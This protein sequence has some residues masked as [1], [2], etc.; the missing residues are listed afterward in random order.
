[1]TIRPLVIPSIIREFDAQ[2]YPSLAPEGRKII[3]LQEELAHLPKEVRLIVASYT[4]NATFEDWTTLVSVQ[5]SAARMPET[6]IELLFQE[7]L[8]HMLKE[9]LTLLEKTQAEKLRLIHQGRTEDPEAWRKISDLQLRKTHLENAIKSTTKSETNPSPSSAKK[10]LLLY[11]F[12]STYARASRTVR[13][14]LVY[15]TITDMEFSTWGA[16]QSFAK[17]IMVKTAIAA[18]V[19]LGILAAVALLY[20][21]TCIVPKVY[22]IAKAALGTLLTSMFGPTV[23][24]SILHACPVV[25]IE[26]ASLLSG[27]IEWIV[28]HQMRIGLCS[29]GGGILMDTVSSFTGVHL[30]PGFRQK[31]LIPIGIMLFPSLICL[32]ILVYVSERLGIGAHSFRLVDSVASHLRF[33]KDKALHL[34]LEFADRIAVPATRR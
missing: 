34:W 12:E 28:D 13:N 19:I 23:V 17:H 14:K 1:M 22:W 18:M 21:V 30:R 24:N 7:K 27:T 15:D 32:S 20:S 31:L 33:E 4:A 11:V 26:A 10:E 16:I 29:I 8:N 2:N 3:K 5:A 25:V 9:V 6:Q